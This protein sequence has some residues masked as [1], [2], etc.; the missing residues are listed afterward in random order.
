MRPLVVTTLQCIQM[1]NYS[2]LHLNITQCHKTTLPQ[3]KKK[4]KDCSNITFA[5]RLFQ[6]LLGRP[7]SHP[8]FFPP[9]LARILYWYLGSGFEFFHSQYLT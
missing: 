4:K 2:M 1:L 3:S 8:L 6:S 9:L 7:Q 5:V